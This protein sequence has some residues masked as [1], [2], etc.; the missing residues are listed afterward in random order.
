MSVTCGKSG[1]SPVTST[2]KTDSNNITE[3][4]LKVAL[5][6]INQPISSNP[7]F[8]KNEFELQS[9]LLV[10]VTGENPDLPQVTDIFIT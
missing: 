3:I 4:L 1:F 7:V 2:N 9:V 10:E 6:T 8:Y 5:N